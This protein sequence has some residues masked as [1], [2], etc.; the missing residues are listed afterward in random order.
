MTMTVQEQRQQRKNLDRGPAHR[1]MNEILI[2]LVPELESEWSLCPMA[3]GNWRKPSDLLDNGTPCFIPSLDGEKRRL[4]YI[5]VPQ[6][7]DLPAGYYHLR[8]QEAYIQVYMQVHKQRPRRFFG[9]KRTKEDRMLFKRAEDI[10]FNRLT[11]EKP[12]DLF[13][14]RMKLLNVQSDGGKAV[15]FGKAAYLPTLTTT[16]LLGAANF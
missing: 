5:W 13:A 15:A 2:Q 14:A 10:I 16:I 7:K 4:D 1:Q 12:N 11:S 8:T 6:R 9:R 3:N